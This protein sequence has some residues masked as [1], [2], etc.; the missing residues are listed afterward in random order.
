[1]PRIYTPTDRGV[2][3]HFVKH[4]SMSTYRTGRWTSWDG[5]IYYAIE[6]KNWL[7]EWIEENYW[8]VS[9]RIG[10]GIEEVR[11]DEEAKAEM[12][13]AVDRLVRAGHTVI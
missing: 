7:G 9:R 4:Y 13:T 11:T 10:L 3:L 1:M 2:N 6:K 5:V 12:M 8:V